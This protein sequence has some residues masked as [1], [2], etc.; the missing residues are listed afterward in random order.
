MSHPNTCHYWGPQEKKIV[1]PKIH[2][3]F[4]R[5]QLR[6]KWNYIS[7]FMELLNKL[8]L[9]PKTVEHFWQQLKQEFTTDN[10]W[11]KG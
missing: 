2:P 7:S 11:C 8:F 9:Y 1:Q 6:Y 5:I 4:N 3:G 10:K